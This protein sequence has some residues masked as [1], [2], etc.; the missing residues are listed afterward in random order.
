LIK[1]DVLIGDEKRYATS[2][3]KFYAES[4]MV[5][6]NQDWTLEEI[7]EWLKKRNINVPDYFLQQF[8]DG[9]KD[10]NSDEKEVK[11]DKQDEAKPKL[12]YKPVEEIKEEIKQEK[13]SIVQDED[14]WD[15]YYEK[16]EKKLLPGIKKLFKKRENKPIGIVEL[17]AL[18]KK[19]PIS[20][21]RS[22]MP[23]LVEKGVVT[24]VKKGNAFM[25]YSTELP[26]PDLSQYNKKPGAPRGH[27]QRG[28]KLMP[29]LTSLF[30]KRGNGPLTPKEIHKRCKKNGKKPIDYKYLRDILN[31]LGAEGYLVKN[32]TGK[33]ITYQ[34]PEKAL[35]DDVKVEVKADKEDEATDCSNLY[36][37]MHKDSE[38]FK[39][40]DEMRKTNVIP[41][42]QA[43]K[44][45]FSTV[46]IEAKEESYTRKEEIAR[47]ITKI[48]EDT[49]EITIKNNEDMKIII[50]CNDADGFLNVH[51]LCKGH[52][53]DVSLNADS[54][55]GMYKITAVEGMS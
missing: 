47:F 22:V 36:K 3:L 6:V 51:R 24:Y 7:Q 46:K 18:L 28:I 9:L 12:V 13:E 1:S 55:R 11:E 52:N 14:Y 19:E 49:E 48:L 40:L 16:N 20:A 33:N 23:R 43:M 5:K 45:Q 42:S 53:F 35:V 41:E 21:Y 29:F 32:G 34:L 15:K 44:G 26:E 38:P 31:L 25:Y 10:L 30:K 17:H 4:L 50:N 27:L 39:P 2:A 54:K 37:E 8:I